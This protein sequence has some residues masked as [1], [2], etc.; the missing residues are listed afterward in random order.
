MARKKSG[1]L[2]ASSGGGLPTLIPSSS[3]VDAKKPVVD[4]KPASPPNVE[5]TSS[6]E[7]A[8]TSS[9]PR[10]PAPALPPLLISAAV[11]MQIAND[12][13]TLT[14]RFNGQKEM[15]SRAS[16]DDSVESDHDGVEFEDDEQEDQEEESSAE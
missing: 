12:A 3:V 16:E 15:S 14:A 13:A 11:S 6:P 4:S 5:V 10:G 2:G 8:R 1:R 9:A 7:R